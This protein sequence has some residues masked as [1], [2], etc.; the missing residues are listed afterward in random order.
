MDNLLSGMPQTHDR[1]H[2]VVDIFQRSLG[3]GGWSRS[4]TI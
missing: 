1:L 2:R 4:C 3:L